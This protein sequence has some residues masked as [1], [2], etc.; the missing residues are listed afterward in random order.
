MA[1][2]IIRAGGLAEWMN[3]DEKRLKRFWDMVRAQ[4]ADGTKL[5][6]VVRP[7]RK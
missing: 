6:P 7:R 4:S 3:H 1:E 5:K 2:L